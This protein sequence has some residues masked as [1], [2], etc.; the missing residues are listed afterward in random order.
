VYTQCTALYTSV[1]HVTGTRQLVSVILTYF[2]PVKLVIFIYL[3]LSIFKVLS[4]PPMAARRPISAYEALRY[5]SPRK[6]QAHPS[7]NMYNLLREP[8]PVPSVDGRSRSGSASQKRKNSDDGAGP[9]Y[10][11]VTSN[12]SITTTVSCNSENSMEDKAVEIAKIRSIC[13]KVTLDI[14]EADANPVVLSILTSLNEAIMKMCGLCGQKSSPPVPATGNNMVNLGAISKRPRILQ[15]SNPQVLIP[16]GFRPPEVR[17]ERPAPTPAPATVSDT[18]LSVPP[19]VQGFRDAVRDAE[20]S[21]LI[22]NLNMGTVPIMNTDSISRKATLA[23]TTMAAK[24]EKKNTSVPSNDSIAL[25]DDVLSV[26]TG[27]KFFGNSTKTY[28]HP[29]DPENGA[30]CTVPVKYEFKDKDTRFRAEQVL[31]KVCNVNCTTP[32]PPILRECI[33]RTVDKVRQDYPDG[34]VKVTVDAT[35]LCLK[36]ARKSGK[37]EGSYWIYGKEDVPLPPEAL[38]VRSKKIPETLVLNLPPSLSPKKQ[39]NSMDTDNGEVAQEDGAA[40]S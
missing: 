21:T 28:R 32:Y 11:S 40:A 17:V 34:F 23:L 1:P 18:D 3:Y 12:S 6:M 5:A 37:G 35:N 2:A 30:F 39:S 27:I 24:V 31:R 9:S 33:R 14:S 22:F 7:G 25:I 19:E 13:D 29:R 4:L 10:A 15:D 38:D 16:T 36:V 26:T 20:K 8:S